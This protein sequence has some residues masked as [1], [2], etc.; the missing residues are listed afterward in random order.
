MAAFYPRC[1]DLSDSKQQDMFIDDFNQTCVLNLINKHATYFEGLLAQ[2]PT[3]V[4]AKVNGYLNQPQMVF[5]HFEWQKRVKLELRALKV[6]CSDEANGLVNT[7]LLSYALYYCQDLLIK[8][9]GMDLYVHP[10]HAD[11]LFKKNCFLP[12][13]SLSHNVQEHLYCYS[14]VEFP[15]RIKDLQVL[16]F[17][18]IRR[19]NGWTTVSDAA[20]HSK[21]NL[22]L[23]YLTL[24]MHSALTQHVPQYS[25]VNGTQNVW[26]CKP[27]YNARGFGIFLFNQKTEFENTF[28]KKA[29]APKVVQKYIERPLL[30]NGLGLKKENDLRKFDIRQWVLVTSIDP[31][32]VYI[33]K[34]AYL[35]ICGSHFDLK[36]YDDPLR[37]LSNFSLQRKEA[38]NAVMEEAE[39]GTVLTNEFV[40]SSSAFVHKL[41]TEFP[42]FKGRGI[43]WANTFYP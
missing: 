25:T 12:S 1:Y 14:R 2:Q 41:N 31:L 24:K 34:D 32:E 10:G 6:Q 28:T 11:E 36:K 8:T 9:V 39:D 21:L 29:P 13:F 18:R 43:T 19:L 42:E 33:Y 7:I 40:L 23:V 5:N 35:R 16:E 38:A 22:Y 17:C 27:S 15:L 20:N 3:E 30:L 37:H 26:I 4:Q